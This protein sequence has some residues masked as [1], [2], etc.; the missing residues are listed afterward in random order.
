MKTSTQ[1]KPGIALLA[2]TLMGAILLLE[3]TVR[4]AAA[5]PTGIKNVVL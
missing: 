3:G 1:N 4:V 2:A 5:A